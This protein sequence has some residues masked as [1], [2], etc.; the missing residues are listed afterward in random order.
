MPSKRNSRRTSKEK[1]PCNFRSISPF[2]TAWCE[3]SSCFARRKIE[4]GKDSGLSTSMP[5]G[6]VP[7]DRGRP[8]PRARSEV[9]AS[10]PS[11][12]SEPST[13]ITRRIRRGTRSV[14]KG[15]DLASR[16]RANHKENE[17]GEAKPAASCLCEG[18]VWSVMGG[19]STPPARRGR[20]PC[21]ID[22]SFVRF[23]GN[24][25]PRTQ[26]VVASA[27]RTPIGRFKGAF[28]DVP[29]P[30]LGAFAVREAIRRANIEPDD[31]SELFFG[32]VIQAG[33]YQN[34][35]RQVVIFS[36]IPESVSG[37]TVN[38]VCGSGM[39]AMVEGVRAI[40]DD[41]D[42]II[43]AGGTENMTRAQTMFTVVPL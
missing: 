13:P 7:S 36:G 33:L 23:S 12:T 2:L 15:L 4:R 42:A 16:H 20:S 9:A 10:R 8:H 38:M 18:T 14:R 32:S 41:S 21:R 25:A 35:A 1:V 31:V 37:T 26:V 43:I 3:E 40:E 6:T 19:D 17:T 28:S 5:E 39:K 30:R 22:L 11:H 24:V 29:A 27:A 34:C